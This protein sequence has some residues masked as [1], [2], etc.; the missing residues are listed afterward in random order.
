MEYNYS[1]I[2]F[3]LYRSD[4]DRKKLLEATRQIIVDGIGSCHL[5]KIT[6]KSFLDREDDYYT[7]ICYYVENDPI[8]AEYLF[9]ALIEWYESW[10]D[11]FLEFTGNEER[12]YAAQRLKT[13]A[14]CMING[15]PET[16]A[17]LSKE[18]SVNLTQVELRDLHLIDAIRNKIYE[19]RHF[20]DKPQ[21]DAESIAKMEE[22]ALKAIRQSIQEED[23][24]RVKDVLKQ[25]RLIFFTNEKWKYDSLQEIQFKYDLEGISQESALEIPKCRKQCDYIIFVTSQ[26]K[27]DVYKALV[28]MYGK[29][30]IFLVKAQNP[31]LAM[32]DFIEQ[33]LGY[34]RD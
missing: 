28:A 34:R 21:I 19:N 24:Q 33:L 8:K 11:E 2:R 13:W 25:R 15:L 20:I 31:E 3:L 27:H 17:K 9:M 4:N 18:V 22:E 14:Y 16:Y 30:K 5:D 10:K 1:I 29:S 26:A 32:N 6:E 7:R 23:D 12:L